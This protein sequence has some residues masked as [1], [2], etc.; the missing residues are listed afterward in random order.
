M[1]SS[2][3][4]PTET[5]TLPSQQETP[6]G[7]TAM[8]FLA[9]GSRAIRISATFQG[10]KVLCSVKSWPSNWRF[11]F[12]NPNNLC[13]ATAPLPWQQITHPCVPTG[14]AG[15]AMREFPLPQISQIENPVKGC[16]TPG[17]PWASSPGWALSLSSVKSLCCQ[18]LAATCRLNFQ[19]GLCLVPFLWNLI[20]PLIFLPT[21]SVFVPLTYSSWCLRHQT[22]QIPLVWHCTGF[23]FLQV[24]SCN[25]FLNPQIFFTSPRLAGQNDAPARQFIRN[26]LCYGSKTPSDH[27][28]IFMLYFPIALAAQTANKWC[29]AHLSGL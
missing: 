27:F 12:P 24:Q 6:L 19:V 17:S 20:N 21:L 8:N 25:S 10:K 5:E 3:S 11:T 23:F 2:S 7:F 28:P 14:A 15:L 18:L 13:C 29:H 1:A 16:S 9:A 22:G 4:L 26:V